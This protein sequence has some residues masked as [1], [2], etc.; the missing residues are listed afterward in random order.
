MNDEE[1]IARAVAAALKA[2]GPKQDTTAAT[3]KVEGSVAKPQVTRIFKKDVKAQIKELKALEKQLSVPR[4][5]KEKTEAEKEVIKQR[6]AV[7]REK[8]KAKKSGGAAPAK[9]ET[10]KS[11]KA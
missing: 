8:K 4:P 1:R 5:K 3:S 10:E 2:A 6:M 7:L 9:V 11:V